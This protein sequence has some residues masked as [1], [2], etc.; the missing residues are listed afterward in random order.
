MLVQIL[1]NMIH[2]ERK[3]FEDI[4]EARARTSSTTLRCATVQLLAILLKACDDLLSTVACGPG[5]ELVRQG[6]ILRF[7]SDKKVPWVQ[8]R[9]IFRV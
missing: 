6:G 2:V 7:L 4:S 3:E 1:G 5:C 9:V 8:Q